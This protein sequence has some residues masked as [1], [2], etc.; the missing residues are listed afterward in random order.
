MTKSGEEVKDLH[1][2]VTVEEVNLI[3]KGLGRL[4]FARVY[5]LVAKLQQQARE[6]LDG[7]PAREEP[8]AT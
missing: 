1:L 5:A 4:P 8:D 6:Q 3:L 7:K 2:S